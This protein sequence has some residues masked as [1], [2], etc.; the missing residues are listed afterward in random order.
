MLNGAGNIWNGT[1]GEVGQ[2]LVN[3]VMGYL[4]AGLRQHALGFTDRLLKNLR[5]ANLDLAIRQLP[6]N[7][8]A[9]EDIVQLLGELLE[10]LTERPGLKP[11]SD[12][13]DKVVNLKP[14]CP[15]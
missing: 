6:A 8:F 14:F 13:L 7:T 4:P 2:S 9:P 12:D 5:P 10:L 15:A 1:L 3:L 11:L